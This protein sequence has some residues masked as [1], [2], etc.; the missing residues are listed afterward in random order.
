MTKELKA[1]IA[2]VFDEFSSR[3]DSNRFF[4]ISAQKLVD[5]IN[6][7]SV[8]RM[9]DVATGT[10]TI[11]LLAAERF[12]H[13]EIEALDISNGMLNQANRY[14]PLYQLKDHKEGK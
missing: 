10:G 2:L 1:E 7:D 8:T 5:L 11:A 4:G 12:P 14:Y 6:R 13:I 3:Y 9:L